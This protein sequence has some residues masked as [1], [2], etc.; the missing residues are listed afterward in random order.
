MFDAQSRYGHLQTREY[1]APDGRR[2]VYVTRRIVPPARS[3][4][5]AGRV[6]VTDSDRLDLITFQHLGI[7]TAFWQIAD[8]NEAMHPADLTAQVSRGLVIP[9]PRHPEADL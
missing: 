1:K 9:I 3:Y 5:P 2:I 4:Q 8:A 7:P 6:S